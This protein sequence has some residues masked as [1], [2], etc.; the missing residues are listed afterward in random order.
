M[1]RKLYRTI[2]KVVDFSIGPIKDSK[3]EDIYLSFSGGVISPTFHPSTLIVNDPKVQKVL[4]NCDWFEKKFE[5]AKTFKDT[6]KQ[7]TNIDVPAE[8]GNTDPP[9][10]TKVV[11]PPEPKKVGS[12]KTL[13]GA[14]TY[15][16][17]NG[18]DPDGLD[19][20][21]DVMKASK[22]LNIVFTRLPKE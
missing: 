4:E 9:I 5:L 6:R 13:T 2:N 7:V 22:K 1:T 17:R 15:L 12:I 21:E 16:V 8:T 18:V 11:D 20:Y 14:I 19:T 10:T 3:G